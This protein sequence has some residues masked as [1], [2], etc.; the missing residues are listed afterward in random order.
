MKDLVE[1]IQICVMY[2]EL[3][4][5]FTT[6][7]AL[8]VYHGQFHWLTFVGSTSAFSYEPAVCTYGFPTHAWKLVPLGPIPLIM[9]YSF[10]R[11]E[12]NINFEVLKRKWEKG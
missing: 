8:I 10:L 9:L 6:M 5:N 7:C 11:K 1:N 3:H 4:L 2:A 12:F